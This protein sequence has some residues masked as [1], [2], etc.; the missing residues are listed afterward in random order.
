M[1]I[2]DLAKVEIVFQINVGNPG[3]DADFIYLDLET[4]ILI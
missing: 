1:I 3:W 2:M 4:K